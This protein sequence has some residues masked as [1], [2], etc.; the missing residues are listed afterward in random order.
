MYMAYFKARVYRAVNARPL[1]FNVMKF[2][3]IS[4]KVDNVVIKFTVSAPLHSLLQETDGAAYITISTR[5]RE[6]LP[7]DTRPPDGH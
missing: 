2:C 6:W 4:C 7:Y 5:N 1:R 3:C